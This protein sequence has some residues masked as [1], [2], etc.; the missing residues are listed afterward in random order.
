MDQLFLWEILKL[1]DL[2]K[3]PR[4]ALFNKTG[5]IFQFVKRNTDFSIWEKYRVLL[6]YHVYMLHL[7]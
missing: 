4:Y 5:D 3:T 2:S 1:E 6:D 7:F